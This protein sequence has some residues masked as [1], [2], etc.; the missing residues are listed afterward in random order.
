M[1][2]SFE[3]EALYIILRYI[4]DLFLQDTISLSVVSPGRKTRLS[5]DN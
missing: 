3:K 4:F 1:I 2:F 5:I